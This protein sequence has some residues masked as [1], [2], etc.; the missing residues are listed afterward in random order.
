MI[1]LGLKWYMFKLYIILI[2]VD[3]LSYIGR[4]C[5]TAY[6]TNQYFKHITVALHERHGISEYY[7]FYCPVD[8]LFR[9]KK[10]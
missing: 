1:E 10:Y 4:R 2:N 9:L 7:K 5:N 8:T 6:W 3:S